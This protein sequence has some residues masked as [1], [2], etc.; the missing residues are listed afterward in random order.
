[1]KGN[2]MENISE[3]TPIAGRSEMPSSGLGNGFVSP[4]TFGLVSCSAVGALLFTATYLLEGV[5]IAKREKCTVS[6]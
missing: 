4:L 3:P 6:R 5:S 2:P 1:M